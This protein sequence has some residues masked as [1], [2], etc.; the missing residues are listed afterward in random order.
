MRPD[1]G[2]VVDN[3]SSDNSA[4]SAEAFTNVTVRRLNAT[5]GFAGGNNLAFSEC[6][7][8]FVQYSV[9]QLTHHIFTT[10]IP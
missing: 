6:E 10:L 9:Y 4:A 5:L 1:R 7:T 3:A 8:E 2:L